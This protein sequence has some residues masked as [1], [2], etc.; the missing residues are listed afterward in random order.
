LPAKTY[1]KPPS[2]RTNRTD[3]ARIS[4]S[5]AGGSKLN[6]VS[7]FRHMALDYL[8]ASKI[9]RPSTTVCNLS[10]PRPTAVCYPSLRRNGM[11]NSVAF[12]KDVLAAIGDDLAPVGH[13]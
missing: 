10:L 2:L 3:A 9:V 6:N 11:H 1:W 5:V 8:A 7:M 13:G 4:D 12:A